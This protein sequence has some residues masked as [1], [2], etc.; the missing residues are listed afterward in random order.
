MRRE[1]RIEIF[2]VQRVIFRCDGAD[3]KTLTLQSRCTIDIQP[4]KIWIECVKSKFKDKKD[5]DPLLRIFA[6]D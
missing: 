2:Y 5:G 3:R 4:L 6:M 1:H